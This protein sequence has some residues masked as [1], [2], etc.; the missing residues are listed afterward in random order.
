MKTIFVVDDNNVNLLSADEAL[1]KHYR[2]YT[3]PSAASMFELLEDVKPDLILLDILMPEMDGFEVL[4]LLRANAVY[5]DVPV[6]FLTSRTDAA[7]ESLGFELGAVDFISKPFSRPVLLNRI[8]SHLDIEDII[9]D[10]TERIMKLENSIIFALANM[11]ENRDKMTNGHLERISMYIKIL[12]EEMLDRGVYLDEISD[13]DIEP[14]VSSAR[15]HDIGKIIVTD[16]ILNKP[17]KLTDEEFEIIKTHVVEGMRIIDGIIAES[18]DE[19]FL[20]NAKMFVGYH[21]ERW[22][23]TG[24][25]HMLKGTDIP[26]QGRIMAIADVYDALVSE[27]SYKAAFSHNDAVDIINK[28]SG[29][30][31][32]PELVKIFIACKKKFEKVGANEM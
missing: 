15:L 32:D 7:T 3:M 22:D 27:R 9:H 25:P 30:H 4:K 2:V 11:V 29:T 23:G 14:T 17:G 10:R 8:K 24:Y 18:G 13:W 5:D 16:I 28:S 31:F 1:S 26:L 21:H 6:I 12:L 20:I 19:I